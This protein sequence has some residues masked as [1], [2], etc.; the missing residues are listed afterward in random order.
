M[1]IRDRDRT[2]YENFIDPLVLSDLILDIVKDD[3]TFYQN[4]IVLRKS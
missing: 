1:V 3:K 2:N 4:E